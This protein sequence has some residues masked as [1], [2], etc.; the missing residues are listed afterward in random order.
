MARLRVIP[1]GTAATQ[2]F[3]RLMRPHFD[4]LHRSAYR[5]TRNQADAE[6]LLQETFVRVY[7][8][9]SE[10]QE[11]ENPRAWLMCVMYRLF[12]DVVR[13]RKSSPLYSMS[14]LEI[15]DESQCMA[16]GE[17]GPDKEADSAIGE[18]RLEWAWQ[19][20]DKVQRALL[21]LHDVEGYT[22]AEIKEMSGLPEG[23]LKS[24]LHR[25]RIRLGKLLQ[26]DSMPSAAVLSGQES[27]R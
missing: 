17:P 7:P 26:S 15:G 13:H 5:L 11:M 14:D 9:L 20:L 10:L 1:G 21:A 16:S 4:A 2:E 18:R 12:V 27:G 25:A 19:R 22:L 23:T 24:R 6:D 3:D 8:K